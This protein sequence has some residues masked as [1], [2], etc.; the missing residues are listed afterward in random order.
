M[1]A[2]AARVVEPAAWAAERRRVLL[3]LGQ[4]LC[5][6]GREEEAL[7]HLAAVTPDCGDGEDDPLFADRTWLAGRVEASPRRLTAARDALAGAGRPGEAALAS[8][9]GV[10]LLLPRGAAGPRGKAGRGLRE[11]AVAEGLAARVREWILVA[12]GHLDALPAAG[13]AP[14]AAGA[15]PAGTSASDP[16]SAEAATALDTLRRGLLREVS[17]ASW[18]AE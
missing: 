1:L 9:D 17:L 7:Q 12:A 13:A 14:P 2:W 3:R 16:P 10:A 5:D 8:L 6:A 18:T 4:A 15:E 11:L